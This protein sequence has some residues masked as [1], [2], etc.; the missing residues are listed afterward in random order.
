MSNSTSNLPAIIL[1]VVILAMLVA[2]YIADRSSR[3][4]M[5]GSAHS[6]SAQG[7]TR[8]SSGPHSGYSGSLK[9]Y[10]DNY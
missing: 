10:L 8:E 3:T 5:A 1:A 9:E 6:T 4:D 2:F 7:D